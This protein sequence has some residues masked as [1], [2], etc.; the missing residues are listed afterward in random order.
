MV[1]KLFAV[2]LVVG[3]VMAADV[4]GTCETAA[5]YRRLAEKAVAGGQYAKAADY[6][7]KEAAV[8]R[9]LGDL[10]A[11]KVEDGKA[12]RWSTE[13]D[14]FVDQTADRKSLLALYTGAKY[15]P[16]YGCYL[17]AFLERDYNLGK[18]RDRQGYNITPAYEFAELIGKPVATAYDYCSYG[19]SFP[20]TWAKALVEKGIA[21]H[22][23]WEPNGGLDAVQDDAYLRGFARAAAECGG[24]IFIRFAGE[25]NGQ[26]TRYHG[27]PSLY[28]RKF[29]LVHDVMEQM[30]PNVAMIWCVNHIP[31]HN[32]EDYYPGDQYVDWVGVNFYSV[33]YHDNN[34][35]RPG[36]HE[37]PTTFLKGVYRIYAAR[38][39]I[40]I[41][42]FGA[43]HTAALDGVDRPEFA[44]E[45]ISQMYA[46]L[47]RLYPR[48][49]LIDIFDCNNMEHAMPSRQ[50][51]NYCITDSR[52]VLEA[53]VRAVSH[54]YF[55]SSPCVLR[56]DE[57]P[58]H[59]KRLTNGA[60]LSGDVFLSAWVKSYEGNPTVVYSLDGTRF[61]TIRQPGE[62]RAVLDTAKHAKGKHLLAVTVLDSRG[63][64]AGR[65][66]VAVS[67]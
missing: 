63:K 25:M 26:W 43:S 48:V 64:T 14:I 20:E 17:G 4:S 11:A 40:A 3:V 36:F 12:D 33:I 1:Q 65:R 27:D 22:I 28:K 34:R 58:L 23:A 47:P 32:V 7:R 41:C 61:A 54:D 31:E 52:P 38:K 8:Y 53:F 57:L 29:R 19:K 60:V 49:K 39:P 62:Y 21:P 10:N 37:C 2:V 30:A 67:F 59:I 13:V 56:Q 66:E 51:N 44:V 16:V 24:P 35:E 6:Y 46:S 42:E 5:G 9:K 15:E 18:C 50:L 45:K 55:L